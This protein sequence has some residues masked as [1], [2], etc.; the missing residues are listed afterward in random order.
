ML[1]T[2]EV[3]RPNV[4]PFTLVLGLPHCVLLRTLTASARIEKLLPSPNRIDLVIA[5]LKLSIPG[6]RT[7]T[8]LRDIFPIRPGDGFWKIVLPEPSTT[9]WF[10]YTPCSVALSAAKVGLTTCVDKVGK[11]ETKPLPFAGLP[12]GTGP[13]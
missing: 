12:F 3:I 5:A 11:Y 7:P 10:V 8:A 6:P 2:T 4:V 13:T 9:T 1:P